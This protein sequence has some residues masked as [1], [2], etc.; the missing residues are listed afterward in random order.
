MYLIKEQ[1]PGE[2]L[3]ARLASRPRLPMNELLRLGRQLAAVLLAAHARGMFHCALRPEALQ[4]VPDPEALGGERV[5]LTDWGFARVPPPTDP[6]ASPVEE[7]P[8]AAPP[9][10]LDA[11]T[12]LAP[13][14]CRAGAAAHGY[15][16]AGD[17]AA[18]TDRVDVY[19]LGVLLF[20]MATGQPPFSG[21]A[22]SEI[23]ALHIAALPPKLEQRGVAAP[24]GLATLVASM[25][26]KDPSAR[27]TL[28]EVE[29]RLQRLA[30]QQQV[31]QTMTPAT[32]LPPQELAQALPSTMATVQMRAPAEPPIP[33]R[34]RPPKWVLLGVLSLVLMYLLRLSWVTFLEPPPRAR[35]EAPVLSIKKPPAER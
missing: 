24:A 3:A 18:I 34:P 27:P 10:P 1:L 6:D 14:Q 21:R 7:Y 32:R 31:A 28:L 9:V 29:Q 35:P 19:A 13:E 22:P 16:A 2:T 4:L 20:Q 15:S 17:S 5:K 33:R 8:T 23:I 30:T 12:Y 25:L 26:I 11:P